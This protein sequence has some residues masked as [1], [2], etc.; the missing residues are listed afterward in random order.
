MS[1]RG[2][3]SSSRRATACPTSPP[4]PSRTTVASRSSIRLLDGRDLA[5]GER[6]VPSFREIPEPDRS[7]PRA[8]QPLD[9]QPQRFCEP[10]HDALPPFSQRQLQLDTARHRAYPEATNSHPAAV[11]ADGPG[12]RR[13]DLL[14][15]PTVRPEHVCPL[16]S[17]PRVHQAVRGGTIGREQQ[18]AGPPY[19]PP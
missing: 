9:L 3:F 10:P 18:R 15:R 14:G 6:P 1:L 19:H 8:V 11:D 13:A 5:A 4:P 12:Q 16:H 17:E 7:V 2:A